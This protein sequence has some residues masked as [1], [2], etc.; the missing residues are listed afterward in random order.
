MNLF[1][2]II[3]G[4][5]QGLSEFL[6]ISSTA[7]VT[8]VGKLM[9]LV[10]PA[11]PEKWTA[12]LAVIQI[13]TLVAVL[14]YFRTDLV[15]ITRAFLRE[16]LARTPISQ[17]SFS[18]RT[19]WMIILGTIPIVIV[20]LVFKDL[21]EGTFTKDLMVIGSSLIALGVLLEVAERTASFDRPIEKITFRDALLIGLAQC[22][23]LIPGSS[24]SGTTITA[25]L[26]LGLTRE[27]AAR[28]S[29]LLSIPAVAASGLL[30]LYQSLEYM[31]SS[32]LLAML[33]ATVA[34]FAS[35]YAAIAFLLR[36]LRTHTTRLFVIYRIALG[37]AVLLG[38]WLNY[39]DR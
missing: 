12:F 8:L 28:F 24:R 37:A 4:L 30:E 22:V 29:F 18:A 20:G 23:A 14:V 21:I 11:A 35:G 34:A 7:H 19:G 5:V 26:F 13:G 9:N 25:G 2:A 33:V 6:P 31:D 3:L 10:D 32:E 36:Y 17:Q 39:L 15:A 27:A 1:E 38:I 16:N